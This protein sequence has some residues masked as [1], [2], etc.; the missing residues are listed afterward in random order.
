MTSLCVLYVQKMESWLKTIT[1]VGVNYNRTSP[2]TIYL[3]LTH[4]NMTQTLETHFNLYQFTNSSTGKTRYRWS[5]RGSGE[6]SDGANRTT[7]VRANEKNALTKKPLSTQF[8]IEIQR[9]DFGWKPQKNITSR[10]RHV[11]RIMNILLAMASGCKFR[12]QLSSRPEC[13]PW[14]HSIEAN[15]K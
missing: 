9:R 10:I 12:S 8:L 14:L 2:Y 3:W 6:V 11:S 7:D 1:F 5:P 13:I 4:A 15:I